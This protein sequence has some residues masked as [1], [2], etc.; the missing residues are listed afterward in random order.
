[1]EASLYLCNLCKQKYSHHKI[2]EVVDNLQY[3]PCF[4]SLDCYRATCERLTETYMTQIQEHYRDPAVT[5]LFSEIK[6]LPEKPKIQ[7]YIKGMFHEC[8]LQMK[9]DYIRLVTSTK[10]EN[11]E[12]IQEMTRRLFVEKIRQY[13]R[14]KGMFDWQ[15]GQK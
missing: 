13:P 3:I 4:V 15:E 12:K 7:L 6:A 1:M 2:R 5:K 9:D 8:A 14:F 10:I 11:I